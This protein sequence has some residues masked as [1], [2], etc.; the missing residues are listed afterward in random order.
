MSIEVVTI[1]FYPT[2]AQWDI[3]SQAISGKV[4]TT[5]ERIAEFREWLE[6]HGDYGRLFM[7]QIETI[8]KEWGGGRVVSGVKIYSAEIATLFRLK[9]EV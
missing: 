2:L 4:Q 3:I 1:S 8:P 7:W 9:F 5:D 6:Q